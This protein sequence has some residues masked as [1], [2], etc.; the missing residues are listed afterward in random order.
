MQNAQQQKDQ[1]I[2]VD[3]GVGGRDPQILSWGVVRDGR[4]GLRG[5]W[6]GLVKLL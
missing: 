1:D 6:T 5:L 4:E 2:G 3:P